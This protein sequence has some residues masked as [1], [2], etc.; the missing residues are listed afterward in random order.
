MQLISHPLITAF[1]LPKQKD[2]TKTPS[3]PSD[4][5]SQ[6]NEEIK[7]VPNNGLINDDK[8]KDNSN[9][10]EFKIEEL[11]EIPSPQLS[12]SSPSAPISE[13]NKE[14]MDELNNG[15][16][17]EN[18]VI[19]DKSK[20]NSNND[21]FK[22]EELQEIPS[23]QLS[24]SPPSAPISED[25]K[26]INDELNN[27]II[28]NE[29]NAIIDK[30]KDN[31]DNDEFKI[32][33]LPQLSE[34][35]PS[36]PIS[37]DSKETKDEPNYGI[38][39]KNKAIVDKSMD[40]SDNNE[41]KIKEIPQLFKPPP[42][43]PISQDSK[44][45]KDE[46]NNGII[47]EN[48]AI[49]EKPKDNWSRWLDEAIQNDH[50]NFYEYGSR[51]KDF[52]KIGSGGFAKVYKAIL[53][54]SS[55][56]ALKSYKHDI[57]NTKEITNELKLLRR[58]NHHQNIIRFYGVTKN[59]SK[60]RYLLVLEYADSGTL[61]SYLKEKGGSTSWDLK[62]KFAYEIAS[63]HSNNILVHQKTIKL[64]DFGLSRKILELTATSAFQLK[65]V[66]PYIDPEC[67]KYNSKPNKESDVYSVGVLLW[68]LSSNEPPFSNHDQHYTLMYNIS[69]GIP[70][71]QGD[72]TS[73]PG[74]QKVETKLSIMISSIDKGDKV[75]KEEN[76]EQPNN[77]D[78]DSFNHPS[79][80]TEPTS[81]GSL[82]TKF[83]KEE[84]YGQPNN[85]DNDSF[86]HPSI[87]TEPTSMSSLQTKFDNFLE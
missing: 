19:I 66:L 84:N 21:E 27:E 22:I 53:D 87:S 7:D 46:P 52:E 34:S 17:N 6:D 56:C 74:I 67:F 83:D 43:A 5:I 23:P 39:N 26:E 81:M 68:E 71:W 63:A 31:S 30:F 75:D 18:K 86:S 58:V 49:V 72:P 20:D 1:F 50:I 36:A 77:E 44:E 11:Q 15:I 54:N 48:K 80:S 29:N 59:E 45:T 9:T 62:L 8:S 76:Y 25:N 79:I 28:I 40:N 38:I 51:F 47:N 3:P 57:A 82:Q 85:E 12:K 4:P 70:C 61:R 78:N 14:T 24:K 73:R 13:D 69:Q 60:E 42:S 55:T 32:K 2:R 64:A 65:G 16:T 37:Q 41:F 35:P 10:D 33:E